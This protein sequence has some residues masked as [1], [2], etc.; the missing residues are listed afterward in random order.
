MAARKS[1]AGRPWRT[2]LVDALKLHALPAAVAVYYA[3]RGTAWEFL[4]PEWGTW[5]SF[6]QFWFV[7]SLPAWVFGAG[8]AALFWARPEL[9]KH[10]TASTAILLLLLLA[11]V[12]FWITRERG[13]L[14]SHKQYIHLA[15]APPA[16]LLALALSAPAWATRPGRRAAAQLFCALTVAAGLGWVAWK[17]GPALGTYRTP[18]LEAGSPFRRALAAERPA[19][20]RFEPDSDP[21]PTFERNLNLIAEWIPVVHPDA[22]KGTREVWIRVDWGALTAEF[23]EPGVLP[24]RL[25]R[26][27]VP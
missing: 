18:L 27:P 8:A 4:G 25:R 14:F 13:F 12:G 16:A 23:A 15:A 20:I 10:A 6:F 22:P 24:E 11:P 9:R 1:A 2:A 17:W 5:G 7:R 26:I 3:L 19:A 21:V